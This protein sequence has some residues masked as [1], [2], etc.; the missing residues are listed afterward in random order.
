L[1]V[2]DIVADISVV[3]T[4]LDFQPAAGVEI[5]IR[6][7]GWAGG[8]QQIS[9]YDGSRTSGLIQDGAAGRRTNF[10]N[11]AM[12]IDN[13]NYLRLAALANVSSS[14]GGITTK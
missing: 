6:C 1:A 11:L 4:L 10:G 2:D 13:T 3:N 14:Y 12:P 5:V 8:I 9:Y 7:N